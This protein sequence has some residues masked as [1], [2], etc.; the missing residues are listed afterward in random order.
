[1]YQK[2]VPA[3]R[4]TLQ[5]IVYYWWQSTCPVYVMPGIDSRWIQLLIMKD[6][7]ILVSVPTAVGFQPLVILTTGGMKI[8]LWAE[9]AW[10][11]CS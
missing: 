3:A 2:Y 4:K 9:D 11:P 8:A 1:M 10:D 7:Q 6:L 5:S